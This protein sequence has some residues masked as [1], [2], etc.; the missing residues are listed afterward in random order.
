[1]R[2]LLLGSL[3]VLVPVLAFAAA[4]DGPIANPPSVKV[5]QLIGASGKP[6]LFIMRSRLPAD[7]LVKPHSHDAARYIAIN[8]GTLYSCTSGEVLKSKAVVDK[9]GEFFEIKAN[10]VHCSWAPD[11]PVD[12]Y[13]IGIGPAKTTFLDK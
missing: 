10:E 4:S 1:M 6:G 12:Y 7:A 3:I 13:E 5:E 8:S 9:P 11:G 2:N